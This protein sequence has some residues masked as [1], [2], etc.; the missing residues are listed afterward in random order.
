MAK[1]KRV[2]KKKQASAEDK[3]QIR[4]FFTITAICVVAIVAI[5]MLLL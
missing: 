1:A 3:A 4:K 2:S 5:I